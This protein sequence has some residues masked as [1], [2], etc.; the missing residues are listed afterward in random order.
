[1]FDKLRDVLVLRT[2]RTEGLPGWISQGLRVSADSRAAWTRLLDHAASA[3]GAKP[4]RKYLAEAEPLVAALGVVTFV[5]GA[6]QLF[7]E[8]R[9]ADALFLRDRPK[10]EIARLVGVAWLAGRPELAALCPALVD[11]ALYCFRKIPNVGAVSVRV[12][13][14]CVAALA[15]AEPLTAVKHLGT[16]RAKVKY[17]S[18]RRL[19]EKAAS[20]AAE[21]SGIERRVLEDMAVDDFQLTP[22]GERFVSLGSGHARLSLLANGEVALAWSDE[23]VGSGVNYRASPTVQIKREA[24]KQMREVRALAKALDQALAIQSAR[25]EQVFFEPRQWPIDDWCRL[26]LGHPVLGNLARRLVWVV[27][28]VGTSAAVIP[29]GSA[30][31]TVTGEDFSAALA[32]P[33][34]VIRLWHPISA[35]TDEVL[36]WRRYLEGG[37]I[38]QPFKQAHREI[39]VLTDAERATRTYSNRFAAHILKQHQLAALCQVRGW[40]YRLQGQF[41]SWNAPT[42]ALPYAA[43][44][45]EFLVE[46]GTVAGD[47]SQL[48]IFLYVA[49]DQVRF[50]RG[51]EPMLLEEVPALLLSEVLRDVDLFVGVCSVGNDPSWADGGPDAHRTYWAT[52]AFGDLSQSAQVR[53]EQLERLLPALAIRDQLELTDKFLVVRGKLRTYRIHLGS[54]NILMD[55]NNQ[56]LCIVRGG[57]GPGRIYLPFAGDLVL[58]L[59]LSKAI[60]LAADD[61]IKDASILSQIRLR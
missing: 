24:A 16:L 6:T 47:A 21:R 40:R 26:L 23:P 9:A 19:I 38:T 29:R 44:S 2:V 20:A 1:M 22:A 27:T 13:N 49:T 56:Y 8:I 15:V 52:Q 50:L 55:P 60:F 12:G 39:Y 25:L 18:A 30:L 61:K 46:A 45:V 14:A 31:E 33:H 59:I 43:D 42:R 54:A 48:G 4:T 57:A 35:G 36:Q 10:P 7:A 51:P 3:S 32:N 11:L 17:P 5:D 28:S 37:E 53:R 41:D 58:P 34:A